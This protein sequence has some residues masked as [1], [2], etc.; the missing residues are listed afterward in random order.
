MNDNFHP[1]VTWDVPISE[2]DVTGSNLREN[3]VF[4]IEINY[5]FKIS[6]FQIVNP[7]AAPHLT[8]ITRDQSFI[9]W[10]AAVNERTNRV[11]VLRAVRWRFQLNIDV[12]PNNELGKRAKLVGKIKQ[13]KPRIQNGANYIPV[14]QINGQVRS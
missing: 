12:N 7:I 6:Y 4:L 3:I 8:K 2:R 9:T 1:S 5:R 10:L 11:I 13:E 14:R